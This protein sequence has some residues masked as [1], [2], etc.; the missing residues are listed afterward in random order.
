MEKIDDHK[1]IGTT[2]PSLIKKARKKR[3]KPIKFSITHEP[4]VITF[5]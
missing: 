3:V 2:F 5:N 1:P 4:I